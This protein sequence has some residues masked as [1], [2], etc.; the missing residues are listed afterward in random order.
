MINI[1]PL[2]TPPYT[3]SLTLSSRYYTFKDGWIEGYNKLYESNSPL[4][5][6]A[7]KEDDAIQHFRTSD[8]LTDKIA[9][10]CGSVKHDHASWILYLKVAY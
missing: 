7:L 3:M 9:G 1:L 8:F 2:E 6:V 5:I 10:S 4:S